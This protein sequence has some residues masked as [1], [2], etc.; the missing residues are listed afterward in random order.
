MKRRNTPP[1]DHDHPVKGKS[2][3]DDWIAYTIIYFR[4]DNQH[5]AGHHFSFA[6]A[7]RQFLRIANLHIRDYHHPVYTALRQGGHMLWQ[8]KPALNPDDDQKRTPSILRDQ[9][10]ASLEE[11]LRASLAHRDNC[12]ALYDLPCSCVRGELQS[13]LNGYRSVPDRKK[14]VHRKIRVEP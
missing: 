11:Q 9:A 3:K 6:S 13:L 14:P 4:A 12:N 1:W 10:L 8:L 2:L 5:V 7:F